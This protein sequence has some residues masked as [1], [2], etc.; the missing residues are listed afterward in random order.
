MNVKQITIYMGQHDIS[1]KHS[2]HKLIRRAK[3]VMIYDTYIRGK[4]DTSDI[5]LVEITDPVKRFSKTVMP[6]CLPKGE[7]FKDN[8]IDVYVSGWGRYIVSYNKINAGIANL[9]WP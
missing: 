3:D 4:D 8:N 7:S 1:R 2:F 6:I 9:Q 5:A